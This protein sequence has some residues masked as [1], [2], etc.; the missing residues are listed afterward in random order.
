MKA[1]DALLR[2]GLLS[3]EQHDAVATLVA[4]SAA[5]S[6]DV[7]VDGGYLGEA[8][9]LK[10]LS[11]LYRVHFVSTEKLAK[12]DIPRATLQMIPRRVAEMFSV[13]PVLFDAE[14]SVLTVVTPDPDNADMLREIQ[15][16][17]GASEVKAF[18]SRPAAV[19][20]AIR[21]YH[22]SEPGAFSRLAAAPPA[23][24]FD[25]NV[26]MPDGSLRTPTKE[27]SKPL[28][29]PS[30]RMELPP[31]SRTRSEPIAPSARPRSESIAPPPRPRSEPAPQ[32]PPSVPP[33]TKTSPTPEQKLAIAEATQ[34]ELLAVMVGLLE[35]ARAELRGHSALV[36]RIVRRVAERMTLPREV[37]VQLVIAGFIHDLGKMGERHLTTLSASELEPF[38]KAAQRAVDVPLHLLEAARLAQPIRESVLHMYERF[39]GRGF[40]NGLVGKDIPLGARL[41][42]VA[43]TY[44]DL[45][46]NPKNPFGRVL[47]P[48]EALAAIVKYRGTIFD[49]ELVEITRAVLLGEDVR[50]KLLATRQSILLVDAEA[51]ETM[52]LELRLLE[53][54]FE[55]RIAR[56][57]KAAREL[58][59][60]QAATFDMVLSD[61][62]LPDGDGLNFLAEARLTAWG[63]DLLWIV[64]TRRKGHKEAQRAFE[65]GAIDFVQK[66]VP[67]E[68]LVAKIRAQL[69]HWKGKRGGG[70]SGS[71]RE[72]G[73][74]DVVQILYNAQKT[75]KLG[76]TTARERGEIHFHEGAVVHAAMTP[77]VRGAGMMELIGAPAFHAMLKQ[78]DGDFAFDPSFEPKQRS[79]S[80]GTESLLLEGM[81]RIDEGL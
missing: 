76:I 60:S 49:P 2:A 79:I 71:L 43:D 18:V 50:A 36:S 59:E 7:L 35:N 17:A 63:H 23:P 5:R 4:G 42:A 29:F 19:A 21:K 46:Q 68:I 12:A 58:L 16:L 9:L 6:E 3:K 37:T 41:I 13:F 78:Q 69:G 74:G 64:H 66:P 30:P 55:V 28:A 48:P 10:S 47:S 44:S 45:V 73:M 11:S 62:D 61:L 24:S 56:S 27:E 26:L 38:K 75:G 51:E 65:L 14:H 31:S 8:E 57:I 81:R 52:V 54:G 25:M 70:V 32:M 34:I 77:M 40:P 15:L 1:A 39:D 72:M 20:A 67:A 80:E 53:Q 22:L 33:P